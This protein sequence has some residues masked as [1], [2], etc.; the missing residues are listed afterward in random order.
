MQQ[1]RHA[2]AFKSM[3]RLRYNKVQAARDQFYMFKG[4]EAEDSIRLQQSKIREMITV[5]RNRRAMIASELVMFMQ[6]EFSSLTSQKK[7]EEQS[8]TKLTRHTEFCGVN[9]IAYYSS[10]VFVDSGFNELNALA[11]SLGFGIINFVFALP[12]VYT[13]DSFGRRNLLLFTFPFMSLFLLFTGFSFWI[14][15]GSTARVACV[16]LGIYLFGIVYSPGEGPVPFTYSAEAYPLYLRT[17]G[18]SLATAT[19]WVCL[20]LLSS[21]SPSHYLQS[22]PS[23]CLRP[24]FPESNRRSSRTKLTQDVNSSSTSFSPSPSQPY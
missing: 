22:F 2:A 12:A 23:C 14:P 11:A 8:N 13:I 10:A 9:V 4:L 18:M 19:T 7:R 15:E 24:S 16:A 1:G 17:Y 5:P 6:R 3:C 20:S 21:L